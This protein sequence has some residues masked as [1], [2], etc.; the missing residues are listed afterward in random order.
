MT[1]ALGNQLVGLQIQKLY[2][3]VQLCIWN[4]VR[5]VTKGLI[6]NIREQ[7]GVYIGSSKKEGKQILLVT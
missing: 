4:K 6:V 1:K 2:L 7:Q 3:H 5:D